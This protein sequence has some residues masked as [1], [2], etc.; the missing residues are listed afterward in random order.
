MSLTS[1]PKFALLNWTSQ[2]DA[3]HDNSYEAARSQQARYLTSN[4][5]LLVLNR[6][7][8]DRARREIPE[9]PKRPIKSKDST[10]SEARKNTLYRDELDIYKLDLADYNQA[11]KAEED[12]NTQH[13]A[14]LN[15]YAEIHAPHSIIIAKKNSI[16]SN[17]KVEVESFEK[18]MTRV[19]ATYDELRK[20]V[21]TTTD[22][23]IID[24]Y[25]V[26]L[27]NY[28]R[29]VAS[30]TPIYLFREI[31]DY[32]ASEFKPGASSQIQEIT[33]L[34][35]NLKDSDGSI[36]QVHIRFYELINLL[37]L[38]SGRVVPDEQVEL[39]MNEVIKHAPWAVFIEAMNYE[40]IEKV[41]SNERLYSPKAV[42]NR[43]LSSVKIDPSKDVYA[44]KRPNESTS[45]SRIHFAS[46]DN[47]D[48]VNKK[49]R[50]MP[51]EQ[52]KRDNR[53]GQGGRG[54]GPGRSGGRGA[55]GRGGRG[56]SGNQS[57]PNSHSTN[58]RPTPSTSY[59]SANS[60][61]Q[62]HA[63][64]QAFQSVL[65]QYMPS[66]APQQQ[67][68]FATYE[69]SC[70]RCGGEGHFARACTAVRCSRCGVVLGP[71]RHDSRTCQSRNIG[72][73]AAESGGGRGRGRGRN[74]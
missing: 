29:A 41:P 68:V 38:S 71:D 42:W 40:R 62:F 58:S 72:N 14:A 61:N 20:L 15:S 2:A 54:G 59:P 11:F 8:V 66:A 3:I 35:N 67:H 13:E 1:A 49:P 12:L 33:R 51:A 57:N 24:Q 27:D 39:F 74:G 43:I 18:E 69:T 28:N 21:D 56:Q 37:E 46:E 31:E 65:Q 63:L 32:I 55:N 19:G 64:A 73:R 7:A 48:T 16:I 22:Q 23:D 4:K 5:C 17:R 60:N 52:S 34:L 47:S 53:F 36:H 70:Y 9:R 30:A 45:T 44:K 26:F 25:T 10:L 6:A 50:T